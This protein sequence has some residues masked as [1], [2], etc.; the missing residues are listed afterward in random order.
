MRRKRN[1]STD[2]SEVLRL[3]SDEINHKKLRVR[4][5][6]KFTILHYSPFKAVWDWFILLL[7][8]YTAIFTPYSAAFLLKNDENKAKLNK[9]ADTRDGDSLSTSYTQPLVFIDMVVDVMFIVD[10]FINFRTTFLDDSLGEVVSNPAKIAKHYLKGWFVIDVL[11][12]I[13]FDLLLFSVA[14][15]E[16][17]TSAMSLLKTAR[18]LRLLRVAR[19]LDQYSQFAPAVVCLLMC[20]FTL[21]SHWMA[22]I[23]YAIGEQQRPEIQYGWL[24][25]LAQDLFTPYTNA[26]TGGPSLKDK[27]VS[28]LYFTLTTLT[29]VGFGN[30]APSTDAEKLFAICMMLIGSLMFACIFGNMT[31]I[32]ERLYAG[33]S[34]YQQQLNLVKEFVKFHNVPNPLQSRLKEYFKHA[35]VYMNGNDFHEVAEVMADFPDFLQADISLHLNRNLLKES[36]AFRGVNHGCL[37]ALSMKFKTTHTAPGDILIHKG[38]SLNVMYFISRG[39][40][41]ILQGNLVLAILGKNDVVGEN[42]CTCQ[43]VGRSKGTVRALTYCDLVTLAREDL[44]DVIRS[45]PDFKDHFA[46][47]VEITMD[48]RDYETSERRPSAVPEKDVEADKTPQKKTSNSRNNLTVSNTRLTITPMQS[49]EN[50]Q[51]IYRSTSPS[52]RRRFRKRSEKSRS[53][54]QDSSKRTTVDIEMN[55]LNADEDEEEDEGEDAPMIPKHTS[56][57]RSPK[58]LDPIPHSPLRETQH[59]AISEP[60]LTETRKR[61]RI[62]TGLG[63]RGTPE[64]APTSSSTGQIAQPAMH[65]V[66]ANKVVCDKAVHKRIDE[67]YLQLDNIEKSFDAKRNEIIDVLLKEQKQKE[68]A[69]IA[70][71]MQQDAQSLLHNIMPSTNTNEQIPSVS[72][73]VPATMASVITGNNGTSNNLHDVD[74]LLSQQFPGDQPVDVPVLLPE[75]NS[76]SMPHQQSMYSSNTMPRVKKCEQPSTPFAE[77]QTLQRQSRSP[78][79]DKR[80]TTRSPRPSSASGRVSTA[81]RSVSGHNLQSASSTPSVSG[82]LST[83]TNEVIWLERTDDKNRKDDSIL[84]STYC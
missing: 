59:M 20:A 81:H 38:D 3:T 54:S 4:Q 26:S 48:M 23:W 73:R 46:E 27:Y 24:D 75:S 7:V 17:T 18:L 71:T 2:K 52:T 79:S 49:A 47:R 42:F 1:V 58:K 9:D 32:I 8:V 61:G 33:I 64:G 35:W 83:D 14:A 5:L 15:D 44:M 76:H 50:L 45:Y 72:N 51:T 62:S 63:I 70:Q 40:L 74:R 19:R 10:I 65:I 31:A 82:R 37:R 77:T 56:S 60:Q 41:E 69:V 36:N 80:P 66:D 11:A 67:L 84:S 53:Q 55:R 30:I 43:D 34:R 28:S 21:V 78:R 22:C 16:K 12:A 6:H 13:P 39:S 29:T 68:M 25:M 57:P